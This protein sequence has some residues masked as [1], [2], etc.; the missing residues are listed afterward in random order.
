[1][2]V[3]DEEQQQTFDNATYGATDPVYPEFPIEI[4][5]FKNIHDHRTDSI[6]E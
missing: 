4:K 2:N 6:Y 1:M 3:F 5:T